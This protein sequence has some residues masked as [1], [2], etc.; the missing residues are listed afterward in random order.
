MPKTKPLIYKCKLFKDPEKELPVYIL[1]IDFTEFSD[2]NKVSI[3]YD[4]RP[5]IR[6][7]NETFVD[8]GDNL[9]DIDKKAY[10]NAKG[11][12]F[13]KLKE[14]FMKSKYNKPKGKVKLVLIDL[15]ER[16]KQSK[17]EIGVKD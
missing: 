3:F 1:N 15:T 6:N 17:L 11:E 9:D 13:E 10:E 8:V 5:I 7:S 16:G 4:T 14:K 2:Y 12:M